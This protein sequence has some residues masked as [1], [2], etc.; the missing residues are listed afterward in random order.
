MRSCI[1]ITVH[2]ILNYKLHNAMLACRRS[3]GDHIAENIVIQ[4]EETVICLKLLTNEISALLDEYSS[5]MAVVSVIKNL[6]C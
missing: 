3:E 2:F 6:K 1:G 4:F 5:L